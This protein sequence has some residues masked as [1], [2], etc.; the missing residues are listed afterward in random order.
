MLLWL[1]GMVLFYTFSRTVIFFWYAG[2][3]IPI[4]IILAS[5]TII[6]FVEKLKLS[7]TATKT[8]PQI[9]IPLLIILMVYPIYRKIDYYKEYQDYLKHTNLS[10]ANYLYAHA[11]RESDIAA[12]EDI[13]YIGYYSKLK[14]LDRDG[15]IS[16]EAVPYIRA[17]YY[18]QLI[19]DYKP[20][21]VG[22][23]KNSPIS[24]FAVDS[25]FLRD[26][27][28]EKE[29]LFNSNGYQIYSRIKN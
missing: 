14:I 25:L 3:I 6:Y 12:C 2:H 21:W 9:L 7:V 11:D 27:R 26:Y 5:P 17:G 10:A 23:T 28:L 1:C 18:Y 24:Q 4:A 29:F 16:P 13:G 20:N 15:L 19:D 8:L 22:I